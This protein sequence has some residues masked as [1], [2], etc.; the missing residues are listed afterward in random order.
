MGQTVCVVLWGS[1][2]IVV[3]VADSLFFSPALLLLPSPL[4]R[5]LFSSSSPLSVCRAIIFSFSPSLRLSVSHYLH[6]SFLPLSDGG[7]TVYARDKVM[8]EKMK[9]AAERLNIKVHVCMRGG[10]F[11]YVRAHV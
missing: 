2:A 6:F 3:R 4:P 8:N 11:V 1:S 9:L 5:L 10:M 7:I